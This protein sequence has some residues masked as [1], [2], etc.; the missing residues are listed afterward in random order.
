MFQESI[1]S[2]TEKE[3]SVKV[4]VFMNVDDA[5]PSQSIVQSAY[6][7]KESSQ[8]WQPLWQASFIKQNHDKVDIYTTM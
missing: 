2:Q 4:R 8:S 1:K 7:I 3:L 5:E 6:Q